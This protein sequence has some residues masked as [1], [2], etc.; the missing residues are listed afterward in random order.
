MQ[1]T[2][3]TATAAG[4]ATTV[5]LTSRWDN[6]TGSPTVSEGDGVGGWAGRASGGHAQRS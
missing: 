3:T 2:P 6:A 5:A 4:A 1:P